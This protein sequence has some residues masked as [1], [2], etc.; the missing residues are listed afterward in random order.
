MVGR[1]A[2]ERASYAVV[3]SGSGSRYW[4]VINRRRWRETR[5]AAL[6]RD[7]WRCGRC[8]AVGRLQVHHL[9]AL[10]HGGAPFDLDNLALGVVTATY[11]NTG[12]NLPGP[13]PAMRIGR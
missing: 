5:L 6:N 11:G 13:T 2:G 7:G 10:E 8:G 4:A 1:L 9:Q 3:G 12:E